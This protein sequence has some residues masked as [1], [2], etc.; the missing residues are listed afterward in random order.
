M[1]CGPAR[2]RPWPRGAIAC[3]PTA[4]QVERCREVADPGFLRPHGDTL[5]PQPDRSDDLVLDALLALAKAGRGVARHRRRWW[6]L[7]PAAGAA[8]ARGPGDPRSPAMLAV[9]QRAWRSMASPTSAEFRDAGRTSTDD[10]AGR[11][12][13]HGS[14]RLRHR[15][16]RSAWRP[17]RPAA[18]D[19][20]WRV[21]ESRH[22][23]GGQP[24]LGARP[25]RDPHARARPAGVADPAAGGRPAADRHAGTAHPPRLRPPRTSSP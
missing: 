1:P 5:R 19:S 11:G 24:A 21:G 3:S 18:P 17:R 14:C 8:R 20:A 13:T 16:H 2:P 6:P 4:R 9:L 12:R 10:S 22:D 15:G 23:H 25:R 7:R